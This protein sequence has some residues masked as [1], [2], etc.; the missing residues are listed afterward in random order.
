MV[1]CYELIGTVENLTI[2]EVSYKPMLSYPGS[3]AFLTPLIFATCTAT[4]PVQQ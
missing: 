4:C 3:T 1:N 2:S